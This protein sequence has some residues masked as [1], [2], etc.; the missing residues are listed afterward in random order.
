MAQDNKS[1]GTVDSLLRSGIDLLLTDSER[2]LVDGLNVEA[3]ARRAHV[4]EATFY[5]HFQTKRKFAES[6]LDELTVRTGAAEHTSDDVA[7]RLLAYE[8]DLLRAIR[9]IA[10][11]DFRAVREDPSFVA[12]LAALSLARSRSSTAESL[13]ASYADA[14]RRGKVAFEALFERWGASLRK[15]FTV[16]LVA[17]CLTAMVE[18]LT[19][20]WLADPSSVPDW[21]FG[22]MVLAFAISA[23]DTA[24]GH[25][26]LDDV[27][28]PVAARVSES[29]RSARGLQLPHDP[30]QAV[31][32]AAR[33]E[34]GRRGYFMTTLDTIALAA[35]VPLETLKRLFPAKRLIIVGGL[36]RRYREIDLKTQD[37]VRLGM[38][39]SEIIE[40]FLQR[41]AQMVVDKREFVD[42][43]ISVVIQD[44]SIEPDSSPE[45]KQR[46][47][48]PALIEPVLRAGQESGQ[49]VDTP[50]AYDLAAALTN[51]LLLRAFTRRDD[52][53]A[54][55][56]HVVAQLM[57]GGIRR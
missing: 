25:E 54:E 44:N 3:V 40:R 7:G 39:E 50:S 48:F 22:E 38:D 49:F 32:D 51:S 28:A 27:A 17:L 21:L 46:L 35:G 52:T 14:D 12:S 29:F 47:D 4:S 43:L 53:P 30:R 11:S 37:D 5:R 2:I 10:A 55:H 24:Q 16:K 15:P 8:G 36:E 56:A 42:A 57:L 18:G 6:V 1:N 31:L 45:L 20:R 34:F 41:L 13:R 19:L 26:H 9:T 23:V 33:D